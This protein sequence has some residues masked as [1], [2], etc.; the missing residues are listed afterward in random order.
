[1][2]KVAVFLLLQLLFQ[3]ELGV[4]FVIFLIKFQDFLI[5]SSRFMKKQTRKKNL[6]KKNS[7]WQPIQTLAL[8]LKNN[9]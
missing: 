4:I 3:R 2:T 7:F 1:M 8:F 6:I 5:P 9:L